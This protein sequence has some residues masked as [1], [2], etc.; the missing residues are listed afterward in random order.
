MPVL[1]EPEQ[2]FDELVAIETIPDRYELIDGEIVEVE[3]MGVYSGEIANILR[4]ELSAYGREKKIGRARMDILYPI[5]T[6]EDDGRLRRPD[7][8]FARFERWPENRPVPYRGNPAEVVPDL[9]VE[10]ISPTDNG[11]DIVSKL[12]EYL[13]A[14][15]RL[16]WLI[17]PNEKQLYAYTSPRDVRI[18]T[19]DQN[20]DGSDILPGFLVPM[21]TLFPIKASET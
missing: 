19:V 21:A 10:V 1:A 15:V 11:D 3:E 16:V 5:P 14:G 9:A 6:P 7:V 13:R 18:F 2:D 4:D 12:N 17:F 8:A 20:L